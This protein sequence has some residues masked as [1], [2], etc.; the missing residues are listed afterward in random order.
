[1]SVIQLSKKLSQAACLDFGFLFLGTPF[2]GLSPRLTTKPS[3]FFLI[4]EVKLE[5]HFSQTQTSELGANNLNPAQM[6][7]VK[8]LS[9][10]VR[11]GSK[12]IASPSIYSAMIPFC[13]FKFTELSS[14]CKVFVKNLFYEIFAIMCPWKDYERTTG[15]IK[16]RA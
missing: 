1:M 6:V 13:Q 2:C 8:Q 16:G 11:Y 10:V 4:W 9:Q 15:R 7:S 3:F 12:N 14:S 5:Q